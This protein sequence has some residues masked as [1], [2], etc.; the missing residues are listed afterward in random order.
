[1]L[2]SFRQLCMYQGPVFKTGATYP[3]PEPVICAG[4]SDLGMSCWNISYRIYH[5]VKAT[6]L[7][8]VQSLKADLFKLKHI[9]FYMDTVH[10]ADVV[11]FMKHGVI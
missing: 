11:L 2:W 3:E 10:A 9:L 4:I 7:L 8:D 1:M 5:S 6:F